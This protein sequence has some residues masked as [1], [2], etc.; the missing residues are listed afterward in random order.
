MSLTGISMEDF[1]EPV[2]KM[3]QNIDLNTLAQLATAMDPNI[4]MGFLNNTLGALRQTMKPGEVAAFDQI[5]QALM[6]VMQEQ[7]KQG[8]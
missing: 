2:R 1:P 6:K 7:N 3:L 8:F 4:I 5:L